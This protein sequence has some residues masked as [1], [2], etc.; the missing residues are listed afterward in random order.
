MSDSIWEEIK[1]LPIE[2]FGLAGHTVSQH[3]TRINLPS[4]DTLYVRL[5][6]SVFLP[7]LENAI[8]NKFT[9]E[10]GSGGFV[11]IKRK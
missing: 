8:G 11:L 6:S 2:A 1:D 10:L 9:V 7:W 3:V 4:A 5:S